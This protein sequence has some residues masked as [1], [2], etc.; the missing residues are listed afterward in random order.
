[1]RRS[2]AEYEFVHTVILSVDD[3]SEVQNMQYLY[4]C[5]QGFFYLTNSIYRL[6]SGEQE[7]F[8]LGTLKAAIT[9]LSTV[10][11]EG[12][13]V[14]CEEEDGGDENE[15]VVIMKSP[16]DDPGKNP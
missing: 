7:G 16:G 5:L 15:E 2:A 11:K 12:S 13:E 14:N 8:D 1:M 9:E 3:A 4:L 6:I 10:E